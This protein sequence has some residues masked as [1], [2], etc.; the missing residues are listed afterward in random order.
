MIRRLSS[1]AVVAAAF[2][3]TLAPTA[4]TAQAGLGTCPP[5]QSGVTIYYRDPRGWITI[6]IP[7]CFGPE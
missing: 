2:A 4:A 7:L 3:V 5:G 6:D 1:L